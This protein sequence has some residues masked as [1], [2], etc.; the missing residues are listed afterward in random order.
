VGSALVWAHDKDI[1]QQL[2]AGEAVFKLGRTVTVHGVVLDEGGSPIAGAEMRVGLWS[3]GGSC[4]GK[5]GRNGAFSIAGC[6]PADR[7]ITA[8]MP[9]FAATTLDT[10]LAG[11]E[12][13]HGGYPWQKRG[14]RLGML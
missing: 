10:N 14:G 9:G 8:E 11:T 12:L 3:P 5:T 2:R 13:A 1:E 4:E 6:G 7:L